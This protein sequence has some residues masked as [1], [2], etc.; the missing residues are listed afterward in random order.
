MLIGFIGVGHI[1]TPMCRHLIEAGHTVLAYDVLET[2]LARIV[3][4]GAQAAD[5]PKAVA[6]ACDIVFSSLP[7]PPEIEHVALGE[8]GIIEAARP[9]LIYVDLSTNF[10]AVAQRVCTRLAERGVTM[11]D[12]PVSGGVAGAERGTLA[13]M[14]GGDQGAFETCRPLLAHFGSN[15]FHVGDI[16]SGC[17]A[18]L[19]NNMIAFINTMAAGEGMLLGAKAGVDPQKLYEIVQASSGAS[20]AMNQ[21]PQKVFAGDF[22]PGFMIDLAYKDLRLALDMGD[23]L[24]VPLV[25]GSVCINLMRQMRANGRGGDDLSGLI[26]TLEDAIDFPVRLSTTS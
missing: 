8:N 25:L 10:P 2:N 26:R 7:G 1:G 11:L 15:I 3:N 17:V 5:S 4:L 19:V 22:T 9:E 16:G 12:A 20:W 18:K 13:V 14:V 6:Q 23:A 21:F 24:S